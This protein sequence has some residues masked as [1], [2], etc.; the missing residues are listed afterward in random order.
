MGLIDYTRQGD[1]LLPN[2]ALTEPTGELT[3]PITR[4]GAMRR[5]FL[6]THKPIQY[7]TLLLSERLFPHLR[8]VQDAAENRLE[9]IMADILIFNPPP[10]KSVDSLA[11][12]SHM[13]AVRHAAEKMML[14]EVVYA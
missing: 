9:S 14:D 12:A 7:S 5:T 6:K 4:Y 1:Y 13:T 3:D 11:W 8:E 2:I 10:D